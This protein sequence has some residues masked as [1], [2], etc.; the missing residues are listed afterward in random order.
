M[1]RSAASEAFRV[2]RRALG[3]IVRTRTGRFR[4][5]PDT[6]IL[7][8]APLALAEERTDKLR[9]IYDNAGRD[10]WDGPQTFREAMEKHGGIQL[11]REKRVALAHPITGLMWGELAA[12]IVSAELAE[13]LEDPD[14]RMA[15][16]SQVFDEARHFYVLRDYLAALHVPAPALDPYYA[17]AFRRLLGARDLTVKLF[18]MQI[19]AEGAAVVIFRFLAERQVEPVLGELLPLIEKDESRHVGLGV[20]HLPERLKTL[21][22]RELLRVRDVTYGI[23]DLF[24]AAQI[25]MAPQYR[26]LGAEPRELIRAAD[27]MLFELSQRIGPIPGTDLEFFGTN[28]V[29]S[30][31]YDRRLDAVLPEPGRP[32]SP[33]ARA[34]RAVIDGAARAMA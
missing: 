24:G 32:P 31:D 7:L 1:A 15:A 23:G 17:V 2:V 3:N 19:L 28:P 8:D 22:H 11:S 10:L 25:R 9:R 18:A 29:T 14:A 4:S 26:V 12:W 13:R 6:G 5:W 34:V 33:L 21:S 27:K 20:L 16:S 30:A